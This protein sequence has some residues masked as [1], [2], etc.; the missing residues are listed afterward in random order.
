MLKLFNKK[1]ERDQEEEKKQQESGEPTQTATTKKKSPGE[2]RMKKEIAELDLPSHAKVTFP[3]TDNIMKFEVEVDLTNEECLWK[4][5][6]YKF[7]VVV[8]A[9]YPHIAPKPHCDTM[10]YH[11]NIDTLGNVCLNILR[12]DWKPVL[13]INTVILGLIFLFVEP[14]GNDVGVNQE[15]AALMRDNP[16]AF[17]EKVRKSLKG[18]IIDGLTFP[19]LI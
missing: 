3:D 16:Q 1:T 7:T 8:D 4:G 19:K 17:R 5:G 14:N 15:A 6:K 11:P 18:G 2:L 9:G 12:S 10:I 13:G